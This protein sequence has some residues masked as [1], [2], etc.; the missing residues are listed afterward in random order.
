MT[1]NRNHTEMTEPAQS[2]PQ[3]QGDKKSASAS[4]KSSPG[5]ATANPQ[6]PADGQCGMVPDRGGGRRISEA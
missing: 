6:A 3:M 5:Q 4:S 1:T 2:P